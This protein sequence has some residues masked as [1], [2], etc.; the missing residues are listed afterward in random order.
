VA[1]GALSTAFVIVLLAATAGAFALT[2]RAKLELS[3]IYGTQENQV[4]SPDSKVQRHARADIHFRVRRTERID[5]WI[6]D[7]DGNKVVDLIAHRTVHARNRVRVLWDGFT[8]SGIDVPDGV[9][10]PVV[11]LA[12][13]HRTIVIPSDIRLDTNP[14]RIAAHPA[15]KYPILSP[16][17]DG[18]GDVVRIPYRIDERAQ[19]ILLLR[20]KQIQLTRSRQPAGVLTWNGKV[21]GRPL[22]PGRYVLGIAARDVAGNRAKGAPFAI[23][24]IRYVALARPR[25]VVRPGGKF[26]IRVSTDAPTVEWRLHGRSGVLPRGTLHLQAPKSAGVYRLYVT[27]RNHTAVCAVVVA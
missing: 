14:P 19:A 24:Q 8:P 21:A 6:D 25:V 23:A 16:D 22:P 2:E 3:P 5:V 12:R 26:A 15:T 10:H 4:F 27:V 20:G 11:K 17:G 7:A 18:R 13:S 1:R 9:Y